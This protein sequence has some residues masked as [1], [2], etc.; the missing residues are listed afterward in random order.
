M[1]YTNFVRKITDSNVL[2]VK[3]N[4]SWYCVINVRCS[5]LAVHLST[6]IN[7][8]WQTWVVSPKVL[9]TSACARLSQVVSWWNS[10]VSLQPTCICLDYVASRSRRA[11]SSLRNRS[12]FGTRT[13]ASG[14]RKSRS[15]KTM[16]MCVAMMTS[17]EVKASTAHVRWGPAVGAVKI[18]ANDSV[19]WCVSQSVYRAVPLCKNR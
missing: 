12:R 13:V 5:Q 8:R 6:T 7:P 10:S 14:T 15:R 2:W 4:E 17:A 11:S 1:K 16:A 3:Y 19:A 9:S 18:N